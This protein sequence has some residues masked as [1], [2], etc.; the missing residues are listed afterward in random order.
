MS[1]LVRTVQTMLDGDVVQRTSFRFDAGE[2]DTLREL[3]EGH[4]RE[5]EFR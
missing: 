1:R 4:R 5:C 3:A 2:Y